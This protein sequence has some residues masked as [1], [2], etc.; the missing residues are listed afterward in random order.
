MYAVIYGILAVG[1]DHKIT[2]P[3]P[4]FTA[5]ASSS[6]PSATALPYRKHER[7]CLG[8]PLYF[9]LSFLCFTLSSFILLLSYPYFFIG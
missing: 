3:H 7:K 4:L 6:A 2:P 9:F 1:H 5:P 8:I